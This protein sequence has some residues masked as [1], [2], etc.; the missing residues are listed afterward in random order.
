[1]YLKSISFYKTKAKLHAANVWL[2]FQSPPPPPTAMDLHRNITGYCFSQAATKRF[3]KSVTWEHS[4]PADNLSGLQR[5]Y[6][7]KTSALDIN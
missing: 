7:I 2:E 4:L 1:M 3:T 5:I 6:W